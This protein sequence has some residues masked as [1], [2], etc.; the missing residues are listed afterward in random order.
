MCNPKDCKKKGWAGCA[1]KC[2]S[3]IAAI[4]LV[5]AQRSAQDTVMKLPGRSAERSSSTPPRRSVSKGRIPALLLALALATADAATPF[6]HYG[7]ADADDTIGN[8]DDDGVVRIYECL[9]QSGRE[10]CEWRYLPRAL[11]RD[12]Y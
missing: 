8:D 1:E 2:A 3:M 11:L 9:G 6:W 4:A 12:S 10:R 7:Y 5:K